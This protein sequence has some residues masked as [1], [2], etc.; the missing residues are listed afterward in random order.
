MTTRMK[1][2]FDG[3]VLRPEKPLALAPNSEVVITVEMPEAATGQAYSFLDAAMAMNLEG[4]EDWSANLHD[5]L[6]PDP[7]SRRE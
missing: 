7:D 3:A 4:P 5:Y 6:Y 1:A 2:V